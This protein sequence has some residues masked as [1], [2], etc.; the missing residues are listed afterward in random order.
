MSYHTMS[1]REGNQKRIMEMHKADLK[2]NVIAAYM[3]NWD[4]PMT[5][6]DVQGVINTYESMGARAVEKDNV[7]QAI[8]DQRLIE[9]M[10]VAPQVEDDDNN[11]FTIEVVFADLIDD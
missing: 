5:E 1:N 2:P 8:K 4:I 10:G 6:P 3:T 7:R 11:H 9:K